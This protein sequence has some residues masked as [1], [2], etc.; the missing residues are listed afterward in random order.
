VEWAGHPNWFF[1]ISKYTMPFLKGAAVPD[2]KLLDAYGTLPQDLENY[3]LK[4]LF[5]FSGSGVIFHVTLQDIE[6]IPDQER[7]NYMLQR[8]VHYEPVIQAP[9]GLVKAEVRLLYL[10]EDGAARPELVTNLAR[11]SRGEM[12][13]VKYNKD[14]TW[15]GGTVCFFEE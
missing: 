1:Y 3:V 7:K 4:P 13:G 15:V 6:R 9:D 5:S 8:K 12:I 14:K 2:C 11:L 10:W